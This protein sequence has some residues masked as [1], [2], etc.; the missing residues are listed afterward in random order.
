MLLDRHGRSGR[1]ARTTPLP[2]AER[3]GARVFNSPRAIRDHNEKFAIAEF[4]RFTV[5]SLVARDMGTGFALLIQGF[6]GQYLP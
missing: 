5:P 4:G 2:T 6:V 3:Q 1:P